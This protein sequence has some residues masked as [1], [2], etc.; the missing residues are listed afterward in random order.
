MVSDFIFIDGSDDDGW[1]ILGL[2]DLEEGVLVRL[3]LLAGLAVVE[4][5]AHR[6]LVPDS[7]YWVQPA[8]VT[9]HVV[10][11]QCKFLVNNTLRAVRICH[12][13][14]FAFSQFLENLRG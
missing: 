5:L 4:V 11:L 2:G 13:Q 3:S 12:P 7:D 6:A 8:T 10:R 1:R 9:G 14:I